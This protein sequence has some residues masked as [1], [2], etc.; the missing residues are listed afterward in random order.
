MTFRE[1]RPSLVTVTVIVPGP[2][3]RTTARARPWKVSWV[4][5]TNDSSVHGFALPSPWSAP[6]PSTSTVTARSSVWW[7]TAGVVDERD[8]DVG[9]VGVV[10]AD[11]GAVGA[12]VE[13]GQA[14]PGLQGG[15]GD[16]GPVAVGDGDDLAGLEGRLE[17][18]AEA[19]RLVLPV[20]GR[21][22]CR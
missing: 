22:R 3:G 8:V 21:L 12:H 20:A 4:G 7:S 15:A 13:R 16:F 17:R 11:L 1:G 18:G 6:G 10:G 9:E 14:R 5:S 19:T 2:V